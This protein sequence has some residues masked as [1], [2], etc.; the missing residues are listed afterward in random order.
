MACECCKVFVK[1]ELEK[2]G[3][4]PLHIDIGEAEIKEQITESQQQKLNDS[5][6]KAGLQVIENKRGVLLEKIKKYIYHYVN[7]F[8]EKQPLNFSDYLTKHLP[9]DYS[10]LANFFSEMEATTIEQYLISLK[11]DKAKELIVLSDM[12]LTKIAANLHYSSIAHLS[13][14]FKKVTGLTPTHFKRLKKERN[15]V[16]VEA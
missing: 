12:S 3:L 2:I 4:H 16:S 8:K 11:I 5:I 13:N 15:R 1:E 9:Y 14:Q 10:Y 7:D 6:Q